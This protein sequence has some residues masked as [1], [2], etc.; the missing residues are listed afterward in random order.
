[1]QQGGGRHQRNLALY[2][3]AKTLAAERGWPFAWQLVEAPG[4]GHDHQL[5]FDHEQCGVAL[6]GLHQ[7]ESSGHER[8]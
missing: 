2:W 6:F 4:I 8:K 7:R 5:M 1:M 3:T